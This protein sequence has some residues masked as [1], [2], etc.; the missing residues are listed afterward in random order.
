[1]P[2]AITITATWPAGTREFPATVRIDIPAE[3]VYYQHGGIL[4]YVLRR[5]VADGPVRAAG[6]D[7]PH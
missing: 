6:T 7:G 5:M 2:R 1:M 4:P 3:A